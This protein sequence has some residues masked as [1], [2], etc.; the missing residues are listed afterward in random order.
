MKMKKLFVYLGGTLAMIWGVAHLYPTGN[1]IKGFGNITADNVHII[2]ME[3]IN[4][5]LTLIFIGLLTIIC[6]ILNDDET[7]VIKAV[8]LLTFLMLISMSVLSL[9]T[10]FKID[11]LPFRL[12]PLIF[13]VSGLLILQGIRSGK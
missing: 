3:W 9:F 4:E 5:G 2:R 10:G 7:R 11:F 12:C 8:Y 6:T 1:V 13:T